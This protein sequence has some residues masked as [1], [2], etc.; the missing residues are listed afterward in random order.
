MNKSISLDSTTDKANHNINQNSRSTLPCPCKSQAS[1]ERCCQPLLKGEKPTGS[2]EALMRSRYSA[3]CIGDY[4]YIAHTYSERARIEQN[5]TAEA[6][7][8]SAGTTIW[9]HLSIVEASQDTVEFKAFS[10]EKATVYC[11]HERSY[12][13]KEN[14][15]WRYDSGDMLGDSGRLKIKRNDACI[16]EN[17]KKFKHCCE[18]R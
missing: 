17:G 7:R 15:Q 10:K 2:A 18:R 9:L 3:Y 13:V 8:E 4:A 6:L 5:I 12:F 14:E 16:C 11:M 1:F